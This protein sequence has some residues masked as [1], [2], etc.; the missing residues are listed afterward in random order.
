MA[1]L[2]IYQE[3]VLLDRKEHR[4]LRLKKSENLDFA[5]HLNSVPIA[6]F[7]FFEAS[8]ELP[9][10][11]ARNEEG[12]FIPFALLSFQRDGHQ[13][14]N[15]WGDIYMPAFLRRYPFGLADGKVIFDKQAS[16]LQ[17]QTGEPLFKADGENSDLFNTIIEFLGQVDRQ[18]KLTREYC[19]ACA[20]NDFF[21]PFKAQVKISKDKA[22][23]LDTLYIIDEKKLKNLPDE[24]I[25]D[26]FHKGWLAWS[27]AH[28]HSLGAVP[29]MLKR[30]GG[31]GSG[32]RGRAAM[33]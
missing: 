16:E 22:M 10:L 7:E 18:F 20:K 12:E 32:Q 5:K 26:W 28:L 13:L 2:L 27:F 4:N 30:E 1:T 33:A 14:G 8:R 15:N 3:P 25:K 6:G 31:L 11:F 19:E 29:R 21:M 9:V 23:R 24:Q 17:E